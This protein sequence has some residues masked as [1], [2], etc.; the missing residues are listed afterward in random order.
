[1][2]S[3]LNFFQRTMLRWRDLHPYNAVHV[4]IVSEPLDGARLSDA[5]SLHLQALGLTNLELDRAHGRYEWHGGSQQADLRLLGDNDPLAR[6]HEEITRQLNAAFPRDGRISPFRFFAVDAGSSFHLGLAYDH[7]VAGG[8]SIVRILCDVVECYRGRPPPLPARE[9]RR[10]PSYG[11]LLARQ[12]LAVLRGLAS[13]PEI[14]ASC[15]RSFR[16]VYRAIDDGE[17]AFARLRLG[18]R[19]QQALVGAAKTWGVTQNDLFVT[20]LLKVLSP[21]AERRRAESTRRELA[22]ASI[23]NIRRDF[24]SDAQNAFAPLL[25]SFRISHPAPDGISVEQ[26][27]GDVHREIARIRQRKLYLQTLLA[28]GLVAL[29]WRFLS[30]RHRRG[31]FAKHFAV[32][33]GTTPLN[34]APLWA[35]AGG[36]GQA[37]EYLRAVST[38]PLAPMICA[39]STTDEVVNV[40]ISYRT[41]AFDRSTVDG[42]VAD[43]LAR[44]RNL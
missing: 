32:W 18:P 34:V 42:V 8:D 20:I 36:R 16:P 10:A 43:T 19:E 14:A 21:L 30:E 4:V 41:A 12:S 29:E 33:A 27:A 24:G 37:P 26:L 7:F 28:L 35:Q 15:R 25:A 11:R 13:L 9:A 2:K 22:I 1:V 3:K 44:I 40:G 5:I 31:F 39:I 6:V 38:G 23:V 17:N